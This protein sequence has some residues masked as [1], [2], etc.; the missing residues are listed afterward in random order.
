MTERDRLRKAIRDLHGCDST[1]LRSEPVRETFEGQ[2]VW[3]GAVEVFALIDH[4]KASVAYAW[5]HETDAGGKRYVAVLNVPPIASAVD[6]VRA[7][8]VA[9]HARRSGR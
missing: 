9:E 1:W 8:T 5:A 2:T 6:A 3:D 4:P 7:S